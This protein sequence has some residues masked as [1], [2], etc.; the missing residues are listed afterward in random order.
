MF[1]S[2]KK[3]LNSCL[4]DN[5]VDIELK[6]FKEKPGKLIIVSK[7][8]EVEMS[9]E[10]FYNEGLFDFLIDVCKMVEVSKMQKRDRR[11]NLY[12][13]HFSTLGQILEGKHSEIAQN[14]YKSAIREVNETYL[15]S[16]SE[17]PLNRSTTRKDS[18]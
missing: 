6:E 15:I 14:V 13:V 7:G 3:T 18:I 10:K 2:K 4:K 17:A 16:R 5:G 12:V 1:Y 8:K 11:R 9:L